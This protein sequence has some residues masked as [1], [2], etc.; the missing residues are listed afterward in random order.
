[1]SHLARILIATGC[2]FVF[3]TSATAH[4]GLAAELAGVKVRVNNA[5]GSTSIHADAL[6]R[7]KIKITVDPKAETKP[8]LI[9]VE[10]PISGRNMWPVADVEVLDSQRRPVPVRRSG[11]EWH[12]L[13]IT[14]PPEQSTL[15]VHAVERSGD[16]T[17]FFPE[18]ERHATDSKSGVTATI[19]RWYDGRRAALSIRFDDSHPTHL[20][21][22]QYIYRCA[23]RKR[24]RI[25]NGGEHYLL[26]SP[27][28]PESRF[29]I[30]PVLL[31]SLFFPFNFPEE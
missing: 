17:R 16:S 5:R 10:L 22:I 7:Y 4:D 12:K 20:I 8:F 1:M 29:L 3:S 25:L 21:S 27:G 30:E 13:W 24:N 15:I 6:D 18:K 14:A 11:T 26:L 2:V 19:C 9:C 31:P 28:D 23:R